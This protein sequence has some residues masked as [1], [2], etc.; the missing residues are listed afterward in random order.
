MNSQDAQ[1]LLCRYRPDSADAAD[2][3]IQA[4]LTQVERDP[5]LR[6]WL[7]NHCAVQRALRDKF[8]QIPV[9]PDLRAKI[10]PPA[11]IVRPAAWGRAAWLAAAA[12]LLAL[13]LVWLWPRPRTPDQ[14]ADFRS[15]MVRAALREYRMDILTSDRNEVRRFLAA[16]GAPADYAVPQ[17]LDRLSLTGAGFLRWRNQPVGM[18][19]YDRGDREMLFLFVT[20]RAAVPD[21]PPARPQL[22]KVNKLRTV[23]WSQAD[24]VYLLAGPEDGAFPDVTEAL[25]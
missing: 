20:A 17:S 4:A 21:P 7:E 15:R 13:G 6:A 8:R 24:K 16:R 19:C 18:I 2:A 1:R 22:T 14:F 3:D 23:S 25:P 10:R 12:V 5:A 9:P 11:V